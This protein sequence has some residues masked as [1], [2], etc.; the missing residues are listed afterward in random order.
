M[1]GVVRVAVTTAVAAVKGVSVM[2]VVAVA[3][4]AVVREVAKAAPSPFRASPLGVITT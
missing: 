1:E 4:A 2:A 3:K